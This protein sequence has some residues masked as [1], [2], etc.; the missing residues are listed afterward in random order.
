MFTCTQCGKGR[1]EGEERAI[2]RLA[3]F[4]LRT[5]SKP[6]SASVPPRRLCKA[7]AF[8]V[9]AAGITCA[10]TVAGLVALFGG[11]VCV[12]VL[13]QLRNQSDAALTLLGSVIGLVVVYF[14][15]L[16]RRHA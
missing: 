13:K 7:C 16:R 3:S 15:F 5:L 6:P 10:I 12:G 1:P 4:G 9:S 8:G 14:I 11:G 2:G